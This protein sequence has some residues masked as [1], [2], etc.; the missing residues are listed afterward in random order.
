MCTFPFDSLRATQQLQRPRPKP[1]L[2]TMKLV[3]SQSGIASFY[4]G[5]PMAA[6]R[7]TINAGLN[8][9]LYRPL[10][11]GLERSLERVGVCKA[12]EQRNIE[13]RSEKY[14]DAVPFGVKCLAG[15]IGG[16]TVQLVTSPFDVVKTRM[17]SDVH[18]VENRYSGVSQAFRSIVQEGGVGALWRGVRASICRSA[19]GYASSVAT[20]DEAKEIMIDRFGL[21]EGVWLQFTA[22]SLS[23]L[24]C[25]V[26]TT[27]FDV[28][29]TRVQATCLTNPRYDGAWD[30]AKHVYRKHGVLAFWRGFAPIYARLAPWQT[31]FYLS[32]E[33]LKVVFTGETF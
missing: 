29:K 9:T 18:R 17:Q 10:C 21:Q 14:K 24:C 22:A 8:Y 7:T 1:L 16:G 2:E 6:M 11:K 28:V 3:Y 15:V 5:A 31:I 33:R 4:R 12:P 26:A 20:Y 25:A 13:H 27:P 32:F 19:A 30:C 23:G